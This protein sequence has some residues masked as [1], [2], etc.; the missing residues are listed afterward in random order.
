MS[1]GN[2]SIEP[3]SKKLIDYLAKNNKEYDNDNAK[4]DNL[5]DSIK[6]KI[7]DSKKKLNDIFVKNAFE[8]L[9]LFHN[10]L[11]YSKQFKFSSYDKIYFM[12][13]L[14]DNPELVSN[15]GY[16]KYS[17]SLKIIDYTEDIY[18]GD[19][20]YTLTITHNKTGETGIYEIEVGRFD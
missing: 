12:Y 18:N 7:N 9:E 2:Y 5:P 19:S 10:K 4:I 1:Q 11:H 15:S 14:R 8:D 6:D 13:K 16:T 20:I 3:L 17:F